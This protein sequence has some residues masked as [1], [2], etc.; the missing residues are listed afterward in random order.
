M[1]IILDGKKDASPAFTRRV[2]IQQV[3]IA[4]GECQAR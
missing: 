1:E 2:G 4:W 3:V